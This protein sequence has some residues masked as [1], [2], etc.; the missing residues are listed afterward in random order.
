ME[1]GVRIL[2]NMAREL[3]FKMTIVTIELKMD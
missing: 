1:V 2:S 3:C